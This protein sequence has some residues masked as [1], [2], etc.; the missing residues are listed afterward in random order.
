VGVDEDLARPDGGISVLADRGGE[1][2]KLGAVRVGR[3]EGLC[4]DL[5]AA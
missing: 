3:L 2:L 1:L 5:A 4:R